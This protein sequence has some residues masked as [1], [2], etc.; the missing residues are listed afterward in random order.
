MTAFLDWMV[1]RGRAADGRAKAQLRK[2][3]PPREGGPREWAG[4]SQGKGAET[5]QPGPRMIRPSMT[6]VRDLVKRRL[7]TGASPNSRGDRSGPTGR[8]VGCLV[9]CRLKQKGAYYP[10]LTSRFF[11]RTFYSSR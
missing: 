9:E 7:P 3:P 10:H 2:V 1:R 4:E 5:T 6:L 11:R 8:R